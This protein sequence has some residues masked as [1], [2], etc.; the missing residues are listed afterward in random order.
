MGASIER[1]GDGSGLLTLMDVSDFFLYFSAWGGEGGVRGARKGGIG[2]FLKISGGGEFPGEGPRGRG[3]CLQ[4]IGNLFF[5]GGGWLIFCFR[6][7][8]VHQVT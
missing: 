4:R 2:F 7:R 3:G 8:N 1:R 6:C 5:G